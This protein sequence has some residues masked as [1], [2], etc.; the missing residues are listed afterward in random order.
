MFKALKVHEHEKCKPELGRSLRQLLL[1]DDSLD[2]RLYVKMGQFYE[3]LFYVKKKNSKSAEFLASLCREIPTNCDRTTLSKRV[4]NIPETRCWVIFRIFKFFTSKNLQIWSKKYINKNW[5]VFIS[6]TQFPKGV[7]K[8]S[9]NEN[10]LNIFSMF[11]VR[12]VRKI[13]IHFDPKIVEE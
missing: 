6:T 11:F 10:L 1:R 3:E 4:N 12:R 9:K 8:K 13:Y 5:C 7:S 2:G